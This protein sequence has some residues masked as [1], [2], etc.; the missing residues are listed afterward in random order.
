MSSSLNTRICECEIIDLWYS[1]NEG[2]R[3]VI[4]DFQA[5]L[6]AI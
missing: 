4:H 1:K 5:V 6:E 3:R 2:R